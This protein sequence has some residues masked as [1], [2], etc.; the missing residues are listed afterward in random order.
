VLK[1]LKINLN[2]INMKKII[3]T[4]VFAMVSLATFAFASAT[5]YYPDYNNYNYSNYNQANTNFY[6]SNSYD[7]NNYQNYNYT[8]P[9]YYNNNYQNYNY[10]TQTVS[11]QTY[12]ASNVNATTAY[13]SGIV[14]VSGTNYNNTNAASGYFQYG[15]NASNLSMSTT[16]LTTYGGTTI[17]AS[18]SNLSCNTTYYYRAVGTIN[19]NTQYGSTLSFVTTPCLVYQ[20]PA[21]YPPAPQYV[22]APVYYQQPVVRYVTKYVKPVRHVHTRY[23]HHNR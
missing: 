3:T 10:N 8:Q 19:G 22:P 12:S 11:A 20:Q 17:N 18:L 6:P 23:C 1:T 14:T 16:P 9:A 21:Y 5:A 13:V 15:T 7:Y 4:T 2:K